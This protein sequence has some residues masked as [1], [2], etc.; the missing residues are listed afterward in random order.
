MRRAA[1]ILALALLSG[2]AF[3]QAP[4]IND[5]QLRPGSSSLWG[6]SFNVNN[7]QD[8]SQYN[9][10]GSTVDS[11][12]WHQGSNT[13]Q[14]T[15]LFSMST[16]G[17][18]AG[19]AG[20][21][22]GAG[23]INAQGLFV[24]GVAVGATSPGGS[25]G[26]VQY[27]NAGAFGGITGATTNGTALTLVAPVLGTPASGVITNLTGTCTSC[28]ASNATTAA[29]FSAG[30]ASNLNAGT[31]PAA[32]TNGHM[33]GTA[34]NDNAAAG[35]VGEFM[36]NTA[37]AVALTTDVTANVGQLT[38][39]AGDWDVF[40]AGITSGAGATSTTNVRLALNTTSATLPAST[41]FQ[42][43]QFRNASVADFIFSPTVGPH[44]VSITG[45]SVTWFCVAQATF[46]GG[47]YGISANIR[48]RRMR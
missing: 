41:P 8:I 22:M 1:L 12:R 42:Y 28:T 35:E 47:T 30:S 31:L 39:T 16:T 18:V 17:M 26:Q 13:Q 23:T 43:F 29:G 19:T 48:A 3:A 9:T 21:R 46:S 6:A 7:N 27:N 36:S 25:S 24:N 10:A 20:S 45:A 14:A 44:R 15:Q 4:T 38:L 32:R 40:C 2:S 11:F 5:V 37:G 33:N 34:T